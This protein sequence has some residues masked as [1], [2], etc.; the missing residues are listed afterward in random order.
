MNYKNKNT[1]EIINPSCCNKLSLWEQN[2]YTPVLDKPTH[3]VNEDESDSG[4]SFLLSTII[5]A[6]TGSAIEGG[7]IGGDLL[8]GLL[9]SEL[10]DHSDSLESLDT[11]TSDDDGVDFGGGDFGGGGASG[12]F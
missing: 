6:A 8:G 12:D 3:F 1:G 7:L 5:G 4:G 2:N 9:G 11:F 10:S